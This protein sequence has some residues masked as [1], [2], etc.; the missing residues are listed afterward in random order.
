MNPASSSICILCTRSGPQKVKSMK[1]T[2][3]KEKRTGT[4]FVQAHNTSPN[5]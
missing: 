5:P 1:T 2:T 4:N 3:I